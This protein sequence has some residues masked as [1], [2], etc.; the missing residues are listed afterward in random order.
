MSSLLFGDG[1]SFLTSN[2]EA[3]WLHGET[4]LRRIADEELEKELVALTHPIALPY[5]RAAHAALGEALGV[6][7]SEPERANTTAMAEA[8]DVLADAV[9][10]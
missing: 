7:D 3:Q 10:D 5:L 6:G 9:S 2:Y 8:L 4:L 1:T